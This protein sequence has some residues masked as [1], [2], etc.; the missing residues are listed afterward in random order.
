MTRSIELEPDL[1]G[2]FPNL[3]RVPA[4]D[5]TPLVSAA[6]TGA[7]GFLIFL[8]VLVTGGG[9]NAL[10]Q[11][12]YLPITFAAYRGGVRG[13][14]AAALVGAVMVGPVMYAVDLE[15]NGEFGMPWVIRGV[16]FVTIGTILGWLFTR[17]SAMA[18]A[19]R[20]AALEV[21]ASQQ[22]GMLA[23]AR[24]AEAKDPTTGDHM[25][26]CR[27][28]AGELASEVG[29]GEL[30]VADIAWSAMLHDLGKLYVPD[31]V[32]VKPGAL[33]PAEW[34]LIR[35][36]PVRGAEILEHGRMFETARRI[37]RWHHENVDGTGYPDR[38]TGDR[39]PLEARI[40]R[41]VDAWDAMT[42]DRPYRLAMA[43]ERALEELRRCS[44]SAFDPD[45][46]ELFLRFLE[47]AR[48]A[49]RH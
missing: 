34:E 24:A 7:T 38:L 45:L 17:A 9:P 23:L 37:A 6:L 48:P 39:I 40:V 8:L 12:S 25:Y 4:I 15:G 27:D 30:E 13:G 31:Y 33:D 11:L 2:R 10:M 14:I 29:L 46:V 21:T 20:H 44:G 19:W 36:H 26:R 5:R 16:M 43:R 1:I 32:L 49:R 47:R 3:A 41:I 18:S 22:E 42:N 35:T 28:L